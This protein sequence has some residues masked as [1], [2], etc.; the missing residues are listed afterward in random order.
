MKNIALL[1]ATVPNLA[2]ASGKHTLRLA[3]DGDFLNLNYIRFD[4]SSITSLDHTDAETVEQAYPNP[5]ES[6]ILLDYKSE[7][8]Y[9]IVDLFGK[10]MLQGV[11]N[12][13]MQVG[14]ELPRGVYLLQVVCNERNYLSKIHKK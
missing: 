3:F 9:K 4:K 7:F 11:A 5:F 6:T 8:S 12:S 10:Q 13:P 14:E 2:L 1:T